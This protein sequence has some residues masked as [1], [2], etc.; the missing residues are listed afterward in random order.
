MIALRKCDSQKDIL[1]LPRKPYASAPSAMSPFATV[2]VFAKTEKR[3]LLM[4][5]RTS[6][7]S[8]ANFSTL[9]LLCQQLF[10]KNPMLLNYS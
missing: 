3:G 10:R 9:S 4:A 5:H 7:I 6:I 2:I 8:Y 1:P